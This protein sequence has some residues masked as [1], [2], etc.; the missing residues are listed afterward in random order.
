MGFWKELL[1]ERWAAEQEA[2]ERAEEIERV[3]TALFQ[4][5]GSSFAVHDPIV[6]PDRTLLH[7]QGPG[8][9]FWY[10]SGGR[11]WTNIYDR[12]WVGEWRAYQAAVEENVTTALLD[13]DLMPGTMDPNHP[14]WDE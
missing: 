13:E 11:T 9:D 1:E 6:F 5:G 12:R 14:C 4:E 7:V 2:E 10:E 8:G 3:W